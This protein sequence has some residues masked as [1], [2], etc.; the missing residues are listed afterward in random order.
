MY[1][2]KAKTRSGLAFAVSLLVGVCIL[3][4]VALGFGLMLGINC[5]IAWLAAMVFGGFGVSISFWP[6]VG[7][8]FLFQLLMGG[9][10]GLLRRG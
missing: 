7:A 8:V 4:L 3:F 6:T 1:R 9:L 5:L 10:G 2:L